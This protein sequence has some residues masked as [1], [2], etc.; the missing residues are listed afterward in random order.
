[1]ENCCA[2]LRWPFSLSFS[3]FCTVWYFLPRS[4]LSKSFTSHRCMVPPFFDLFFVFYSNTVGAQFWFISLFTFYYNWRTSCVARVVVRCCFDFCFTFLLMRQFNTLL[5]SWFVVFLPFSVSFVFFSHFLSLF[6][7]LLYLFSRSVTL[8][9]A[10][11]PCEN[12]F[13]FGRW[14]RKIVTIF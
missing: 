7:T 11:S 6:L 4:Q 14:K 10:Q 5:V 1:M 8:L 3:S 9:I 12:Y 2:N 13:R